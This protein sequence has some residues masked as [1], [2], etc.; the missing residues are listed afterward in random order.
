[1]RYH[2]PRV[3]GRDVATSDDVTTVTLEFLR[4]PDPPPIAPGA[5]YCPP[6]LGH[7][8]FELHRLAE[9]KGSILVFE[10][11]A[12]VVVGLRDD[13]RCPRMSDN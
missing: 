8:V 7:W 6:D 5:L 4:D 9:R 1:M 2:E 13:F 3:T 10:T 12:S 11:Y